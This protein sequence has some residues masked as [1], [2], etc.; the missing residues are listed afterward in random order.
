MLIDYTPQAFRRQTNEVGID[1]GIKT[2]ATISDGVIVDNIKTTAKYADKLA[3]EQRRLSKMQKGSN[4]RAKQKVKIAKLHLKIANIRND[5]LHKTSTGIAKQYS[6]VAIEDLNVKGMLANHKLAKSIADCS[7]SEFV[8]Q[9][10]YKG[11]WYGCEIRKI[12]R[13][14]PSSQICSVCGYKNIEVKDLSIR[15]WDCPQCQM[16]HDRDVNASK[17]ILRYALSGRQEEVVDT[18]NNSCIER[19]NLGVANA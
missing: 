16:R 6:F 13:F 18:Y 1:M 3:R 7:W 8:R 15:E 5:F 12:G 4:N 17:N 10:E 2:F 11:E 14:E 9:L 19:Q